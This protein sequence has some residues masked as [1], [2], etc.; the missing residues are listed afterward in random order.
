MGRLTVFAAVTALALTPALAVAAE[1]TFGKGDIVYRKE[2]SEPLPNAFG[3]KDIFGR[4]RQIGFVEIRYLG[5]SDGVAHFGR[6]DVR[7]I[8][9]QTTM[10]SM[11][12]IIHQ[13]RDRDGNER[14]PM[15]L[16]NGLGPA[17]KSSMLSPDEIALDLDVAS[18]PM[19]IVDGV[20]LRVMEAA[21]NHVTIDMPDK[22]SW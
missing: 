6:R 9:N 13:G 2:L 7:I 20:A 1:Q 14:A 22:K 5:F 21:P 8:S 16:P 12:L 18:D 10:N 15:V 11:P 17:I 19:L 3:G 4:K